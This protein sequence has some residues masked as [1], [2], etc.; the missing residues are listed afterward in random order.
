LKEK[1]ALPRQDDTGNDFKRNRE[2][3]IDY[4]ELVRAGSNSG[5]FGYYK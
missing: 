4:S 1:L 2:W 5:V 3:W